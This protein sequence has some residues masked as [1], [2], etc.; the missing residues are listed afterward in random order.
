MEL[1]GIDNNG[2]MDII[3]KKYDNVLEREIL[4]TTKALVKSLQSLCSVKG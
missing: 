1:I 3:N 2:S 4:S